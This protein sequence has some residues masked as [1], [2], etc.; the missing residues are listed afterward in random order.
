M[1]MMICISIHSMWKRD[2]ENVWRSVRVSQ[3]SPSENIAVVCRIHE[4]RELRLR[5][6][7]RYRR[8]LVSNSIALEEEE[9]KEEE[10]EQENAMSL[11]SSLLL[12]PRQAPSTA[13]KMTSKVA[14][15][16][17][18]V[19]RT[20]RR[21]LNCLLEMLPLTPTVLV[22]GV[23]ARSAKFLSKYHSLILIGTMQNS[24]SNITKTHLTLRARHRYKT[25]D[26][27]FSHYFKLKIGDDCV[28]QKP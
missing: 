19:D 21:V 9:E 7:W 6:S 24:R 14:R 10:K 27:K 15:T 17:W 22:R 8:L 12:P 3:V 23:R 13:S 1:M 18:E 16:L 11:Q 25:Q 4:S 2:E 20:R 5:W 26:E 28:Q